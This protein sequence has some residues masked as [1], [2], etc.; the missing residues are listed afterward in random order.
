MKG[1]SNYSPPW[2]SKTDGNFGEGLGAKKIT[3]K[4]FNETFSDF[5]ID[6]D[7]AISDFDAK[8]LDEVKVSAKWGFGKVKETITN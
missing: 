5:V 6:F 1:Y 4:G 7:D 8:V 2:E 3:G